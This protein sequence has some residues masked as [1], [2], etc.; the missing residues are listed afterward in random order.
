MHRET[1]EKGASEP[2]HFFYSL[3]CKSAVHMS[4]SRGPLCVYIIHVPFG[5]GL[6]PVV[7]ACWISVTSI[8]SSPLTL[9]GPVPLRIA[10]F[11]GQLSL[12]GGLEPV[13][14]SP[15]Q[16]T[17]VHVPLCLRSFVICAAIVANK[18]N[19]SCIEPLRS[20]VLR[21]DGFDAAAPRSS[22]TTNNNNVRT[23]RQW[24]RQQQ[25]QVVSRVCACV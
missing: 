20:G 3:L 8:Q 24:R 2:R 19:H 14:G 25:V 11:L 12:D 9:W 6:K 16:K 7:P 17:P 15:R 5:T 21:V 18:K 10:P 1:G 4:R 23:W 22:R 13:F